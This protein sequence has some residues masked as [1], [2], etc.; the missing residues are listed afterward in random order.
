[1]QAGK[2]WS[3]STYAFSTANAWSVNM[4]FGDVN[5]AGKTIN[6]FYVWPVRSEMSGT[7][8]TSTLSKTGQTTCYNASNTA[9][10]CSGTTGQDGELM[11]GVAWP[12]PRFSD[13]GDKTVTDNLTGLNWT[14][15]GNPAA[16]AYTWQ[17][18]LNYINTLNSENYLGNNDWRLPN[19]NELESLVNKGQ[20]NSAA[21]LNGQ[22]F[23]N[24]QAKYYWSSSTY[25]GGIVNNAWGVGMDSGYVNYE[26]KDKSFYVWPVRTGLSNAVSS[27]TLT[28]AKVFLG[29]G[30]DNFT[31]SNSGATL[32]GNMGINTVTIASGATGVI[33]DQNIERIN[34]SGTSSNYT[35]KQTGNMINVYDHS[36]LLLIVRAPVQG[37][38][39]GTVLSFG[40]GIA[41]TSALLT[42]GGVMTLGGQPVSTTT[43]TA[44]TPA[45][46]TSTLSTA[47]NTI[48][49]VF[50]SAGGD[51]FTVSNSGTTTLYGNIGIDSVTI[52][53]GASNVTLDQNIEQINFTGASSSYAFK[54]TGNIIN[55]YYAADITTLLVRAPV[56]GDTDGT[57]ILFSN[58]T[59]SAKLAGGVMTLDGKPLSSG[60]PSVLP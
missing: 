14:R 28:N 51:N 15:D 25:A 29:A 37:D 45:T 35:F 26:L 49:K 24:V 39:D 32:Y 46:T 10:V 50:L 9:V 55:V 16:V 41:F 57:Q 2:Y 5:Y 59:A 8:S 17:Q 20:S 47:T 21:Y 52:A 40:N 44:L 42:T 4:S 56:Q 18:A 54:Q 6:Y 36:G 1:I 38:Y 60:T 11:T 27:L 58:V 13:N 34:L 12:S 22:G 3:S 43:P 31:V 7:I 23:S 48:A 30:G 53:A 19:R 33:L